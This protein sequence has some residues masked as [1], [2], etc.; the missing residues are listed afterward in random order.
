MVEDKLDILLG[1]LD[2]EVLKPFEELSNSKTVFRA[3]FKEQKCLE[4]ILEFSRN[5]LSHLAD[6]R[7]LSRN[8]MP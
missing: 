3:A 1:H 2:L 8:D 6:L 4:G 5:E 7:R